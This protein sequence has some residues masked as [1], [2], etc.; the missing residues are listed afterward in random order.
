MVGVDGFNYHRWIIIHV[1]SIVLTK[2]NAQSHLP[3]PDEPEPVQGPSSRTTVFAVLLT[4]FILTGLLSFYIRQCALYNPDSP[5][6]FRRRAADDGCSRLGGLDNTVVESFPVFS[7]SSVKESK[8][9]SGDLEC[10]IC[11]N[12][13]EKRETVRLLPICSHLFHIDCI[14]AWLYSH[15]TCPVCRSDPSLAVKSNIIG[16]EDHIHTATRSPMTDQV[17]IDIDPTGDSVA[18]EEARSHHRKPSTEIA[19]KFPRSNSTGHSIG[20]LGDGTERF[21]LRLPEDVKMRIMAEKGRRMKRTRSFDANMTAAARS[22]Y[23]IGSFNW[24]ERWG[25][26]V[27]KSNLGSVKSQKSNGE[28]NSSSV[29]CTSCV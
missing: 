11:L 5:N 22:S 14:D 17:A 27:A 25:L 29:K 15:A 13:F 20:R 10:A 19:G 6:H 21:T 1:A 18:G 28:S 26:F 24:T 16:E 23:A 8:I 4:L 3:S 12:E 9:G 2:I 7:Y